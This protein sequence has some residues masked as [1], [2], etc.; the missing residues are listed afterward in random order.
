MMDITFS[1]PFFRWILGQ[2]STLELSD[3]QFIDTT[4]FKSLSQ[5]NDVVVKKKAMEKDRSH[6]PETLRLALG[7]LTLDG[8]PIEDLG[9]DFV[10][11]GYA[12]IEL[13]V[14][15]IP[16]VLPWGYLLIFGFRHQ[17]LLREFHFG[18]CSILMVLY[19]WFT[20]WIPDLRFRARSSPCQNYDG[21]KEC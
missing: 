19:R 18:F 1:Q 10:L 7:N 6:T 21:L 12:G 2:E 14:C 9:L 20:L 17:S 16:R 4:L 8:L 5:L 11:P 15:K 13:K 3:M